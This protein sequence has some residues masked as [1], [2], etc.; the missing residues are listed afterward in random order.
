M[1]TSLGTLGA[2]HLSSALLFRENRDEALAFATHDA[3]QGLAARANGFPVLG[4]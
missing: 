2:L 4:L 1:A 3:R